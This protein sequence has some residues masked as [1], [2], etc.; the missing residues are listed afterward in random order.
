M[1]KE[2]KVVNFTE[3]KIVGPLLR[4]ALPVM[5][6]LFLQSMYGAVDLF[7]VGHFAESADV[8]AVSTGSQVILTLNSLIIG[9]SMGITIVL[10]QQIGRGEAEKGGETI[11]SGIAM[12]AVVGL[13]LTAAMAAFAAP[14]ATAL[15]A[16]PE[17]FDQ[18]VAYVRICGAGCIVITAYNLIGSIFRGLG[19]SVT[20]LIAVLIACVVN[21][22]GDLFLVAG[23]HMGSAGAAIATVGA[24]AVSVILS[25]LIISRK[26]L[27]FT[28]SRRQIR[29]NRKI[30]SHIF[31]LGAP[32]ALQDTL[33]GFS[34]LFILAV[35]NS[36]GLIASAG[37]GVAEKVC[38]FVMLVPSAFM[39]SMSAFVAQNVGAGK[40]HRA[41]RS[42]R[43]GIMVSLA[44]GVLMFY[45]VFF[46][47][48]TLGGIFS[49]D[50]EVVSAGVEYLKA[51][52]IDCL[53]TAFLFC[54]IGFFN[55]FGLTRFVMVQGLV[56]AFLIRVPGSFLLS[57][58]Q[59]VS[60]FRIGLAIPASTVV[61]IILCF[62]CMH[63]LKKR[64]DFRKE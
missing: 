19:D 29:F 44:F 3:G 45:L 41:Q 6:A 23:L 31:R 2:K 59:P 11:G 49:K 5:F 28:F 52:G 63:W 4:F 16:P 14:F 32:V 30:I 37:V 35:I 8:S 42:L 40:Y 15:Q 13:I 24:Q 56:G 48:M 26:Q 53:L 27:P 64:Y 1:A 17:A 18:T 25:L 7:V 22:A 51:Y 61:Q 46:H 55:G 21:I 12:F 36:I 20:P 33:V 62:V 38:A 60:L 57:K 43:Y 58:V 54:F 9:L 34:F 50:T 47:G 39:Q 10:G